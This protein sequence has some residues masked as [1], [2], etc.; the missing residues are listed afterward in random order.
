MPSTS[1]T[2]VY[3][4]V[5]ALALDKLSPVIADNIS[6]GTKLFY[7]MK[8]A[9]NWEGVAF[10]G[11]QLRK[12]VMS[13]LVPLKPLGSYGMVN[14]NP[15]DG[16]T[17]AYFSWV[18]TAAHVTFSDM[19][20]FQ[21]GGSES[22]Q[23]IVEAKRRQAEASLIDIFNQ[24]LLR[25]QGAVDGISLET[26]LTSSLDG[27]VFINP[28]PLLI[29][30]DPTTSTTVGGVD[31]SANPWWRNQIQSSSASTLIAFQNELRLLHLKCQR[32]GG[33][34]HTAPDFHCCDERTFAVYE[35]ALALRHQNPDY[36][37]G[38]IPFDNVAFKGKPAF[39]DEQVADVQTGST[40]ITKGTWY[41]GNSYW[42][43]FMFD[44]RK[45]F[46]VEDSIRPENQLLATALMPVRGALWINNR[47]KLG[48]AFNIDLT[49]LEAAT[50]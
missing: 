12:A 39:P 2:V 45:S 42:M 22:I 24:S 4:Q 9:G 37:M 14:V 15:I 25:G 19:E 32:G 41:M 34:A 3:S 29:K 40:T 10:G 47:R 21:T 8:K 33:G 31:Q 20:E 17:A 35:K 5:A 7:F 44:S 1:Q 23:A 28:L 13:T 49:T 6:T 26:P 46:K 27:S 18:Q 30:K 50:S 38:D 11:R 48:V 16:D 36:K 43:G